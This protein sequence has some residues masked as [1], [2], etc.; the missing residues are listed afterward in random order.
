MCVR[1]PV[2]ADDA[3]VR[4]DLH[5]QNL[6][7][8]GIG[9]R[10]QPETAVRTLRLQRHLLDAGWQRLRA[11][12]TVTAPPTL[13]ARGGSALTWHTALIERDCFVLAANTRRRRSRICACAASSAAFNSA[14]R[15]AN[16]AFSA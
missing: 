16:H 15:C 5:P 2:S 11:R 13:L 9:K 10:A 14:S 7:I 6:G 8:L 12:A 4:I 1:K 3:A